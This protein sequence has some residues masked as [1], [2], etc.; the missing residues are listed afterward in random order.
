MK[1]TFVGS[2]HGVPEAHRKCQSI[3]IEV[4]DNV[5]FVDMGT[6]AINALRVR[7]IPIEAVKG[8]FITHMHGDHTNGLP[9]FVDLITW[10]FTAADP[11]ICIPFVEAGRVIND[12]LK[13]TQNKRSK[14]IKYVETNEGV[15]FDDGTLKMTAVPTQHCVR[16]FSYI[17][18]AE[19]KTVLFTGD[20]RGPATDFPVAAFEYPLDLIV[21]ESAHFEA[22][23]Y[24]PVFEGHDIKRLCVT[25]YSDRFVTS[26]M[27]LCNELGARGVQTCLATDDLEIKL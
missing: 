7:G 14:D 2:S 25:H 12:W 21:C 9:E 26:A 15:V 13:I 8:V 5:Y 16:S 17:A 11:T 10:F 22:T 6:S 27:K 19:G 20:L 3:M 4:G 23:D 24:I 18:Q 1:I